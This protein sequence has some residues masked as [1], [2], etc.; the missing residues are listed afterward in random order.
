MA[1]GKR[2]IV[3]SPAVRADLSAV[4][5]YYF[6]VAGLQTADRMLREIYAR[7]AVLEQHPYAGRAREELWPRLRSIVVSPYVVFYRVSDDSVE[8]VRVLDG[9]RDL[10]E[11]FTSGG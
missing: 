3:W 8:I 10:E 1:V 4:W 9:R 2:P 5:L 11:I 6:R 7:C